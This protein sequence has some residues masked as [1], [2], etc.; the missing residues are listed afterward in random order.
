MGKIVLLVVVMGLSFATRGAGPLSLVAE[1]DLPTGKEQ[2][3]IIFRDSEVQLI[4]NSNF[5]QS[6]NHVTKLGNFTAKNTEALNQLKLIVQNINERL[7]TEKEFIPKDSLQA[8]NSKKEK[9]HSPHAT[10]YNVSGRKLE[11]DSGYISIVAPFFHRIFEQADWQAKDGVQ[12]TLNKKKIELKYLGDSHVKKKD[13]ILPGKS[14][15]CP[16]QTTHQIGCRI[17]GFG[18]VYLTHGR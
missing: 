4:L 13:K 16:S 11:N 18:N 14:K 1:R 7:A 5:L 6:P 10:V 8:K 17:A 2:M 15:D 9:S 3:A 12:V